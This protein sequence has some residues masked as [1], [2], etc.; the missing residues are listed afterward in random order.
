MPATIGHQRAMLLLIT[1]LA[2]EGDR[3]TEAQELCRYIQQRARA[4]GSITPVVIPNEP[5]PE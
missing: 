1:L 3:S 2:K 5:F 4:D